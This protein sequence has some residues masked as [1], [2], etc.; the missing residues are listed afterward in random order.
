MSFEF[1]YERTSPGK[2]QE[3][4]NDFKS[5]RKPL[6]NMVTLLI[7]MYFRLRWILLHSI[8]IIHCLP[9]QFYDNSVRMLTLQLDCHV[10]M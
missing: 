9:V 4:K 2:C 8:A 10:V 3:V 7:I 6:H 1:A 5:Q